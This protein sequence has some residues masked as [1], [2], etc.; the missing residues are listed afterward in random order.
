MGFYCVERLFNN[1]MYIGMTE[2]SIDGAICGILWTL[3]RSTLTL[4]VA[5]IFGAQNIDT[6]FPS[7]YA[8]AVTHDLDGRPN[9]HAST[10]GYR[11]RWGD[12]AEM[13]G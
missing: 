3:T 10:E 1:A 2:D 9:L 12:M 4:F 11:D 6:A 8:A 5:R 13:V 7:H